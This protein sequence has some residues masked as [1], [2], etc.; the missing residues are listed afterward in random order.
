MKDDRF[1]L[2]YHLMPPIGW[3]N[4][5][6]GLIQFKGDYHVFYQHYPFE[7]RQGPMHWGHAKSADLVH[8]E[9][10]PV[11]LAPS[12]PYEMD[13]SGSAGGCWSGSAVEENGKLA[14]IYTAHV[15]GNH[16]VEVQCLAVS[17][18]G[19]RFEKETDNPV[20]AGPPQNEVFGFRDPKVWKHG[21]TWYLVIGCGKDGKGK[22]LLYQSA[23]LCEWRCIGA[24]AESDGT[25]G[26]MWECPD[27][28][29]LGDDG[30]HVLIISPMNLGATKTM[31]VS[32]TFDYETGILTSGYK[33]RLDYGYDFY[34]PQTLID[35]Q[36]R[37][38]LIAWMNIWGS[39]MPERADNWLGAMTIPRELKLEQDGTLRMLPVSEL[40]KLRGTH[41]SV[42]DRT[43]EAGV[44]LR[45]SAVRGDA[46]EIV[47][48]FDVNASD[49]ESFGIR[50]RVSPDGNQ[51][52]EI[53]YRTDERTLFV[54]RT[55]SGIGDGGV[56]EVA[57]TPK[58]DGRL[59]L[60]LFL[61]RSSVEIFANNGVKTMTNR[62]YPDPDSL[63]V[64]LFSSGGNALLDA[65]EAWELKSIW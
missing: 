22:A 58:E 5:P 48:E 21:D 23:D 45:L 41:H 56:S 35:D 36:G 50:L 64:V 20:I 53:G 49:A 12:E 2:H 14:L 16:P 19:I 59:K 57:V 31:Y 27:L 18:D 17:R 29:P 52:T 3:M 30:R 13:G 38:I 39:S 24:A 42:A 60:H 10:L 26:D 32:G 65:F 25:M 9:H 1:R 61:D 55:R 4:D 44:D 47:A 28:F 54:D 37:R 51:Y 40:S 11:A 62:I 63:G 7:P 46:L 6:N 8:W 33:E 15:D 43:I 34:A